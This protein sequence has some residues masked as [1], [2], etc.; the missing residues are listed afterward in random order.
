LPSQ[1]PHRSSSAAG[2]PPERHVLP[3]LPALHAGAPAAAAAIPPQAGL[4]SPS[5]RF[6]S[7]SRL[8]LFHLP[9]KLAC[10]A[11]AELLPPLPP[12]PFL[13]LASGHRGPPHPSHHCLHRALREFPQCPPVLLSPGPP[14]NSGR[15][16]A[17]TS[18]R[19]PP[20]SAHCGP[21]ISATLTPLGPYGRLSHAPVKL[22]DLIPNAS[23]HWTFAPAFHL[24]RRPPASAELPLLAALAPIPSVPR[25]VKG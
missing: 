24:R 12:N 21:A 6:N 13:R 14:L 17:S 2:A 9:R 20:P 8:P 22:P 23:D 11:C 3:R 15:G 19:L 16:A 18:A 4:I 10:P 25:C 1:S 5:L 7:I